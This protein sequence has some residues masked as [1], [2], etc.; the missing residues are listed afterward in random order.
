[1]VSENDVLHIAKLADIGIAMS[2]LGEFTEQFNA[3]LGYFNILDNLTTDGD[4]DCPLV[5][6]FREDKVGIPLS[7]K[8]A[9]A[10]SHN[11]ENG[12]IRAP[13]VI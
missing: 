8:K 5:N 10:N 13:R 6:V 1:M 7:Q 3:I 2:E 4:F 9:L 11:P 12:Y